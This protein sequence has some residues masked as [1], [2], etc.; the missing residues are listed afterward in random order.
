MKEE[1]VLN[2]KYLHYLLPARVGLGPN[3]GSTLFFPSLA[4]VVVQT[5]LL[6]WLHKTPVKF[7]KGR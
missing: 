4:I 1:V 6:W 7:V 2:G 3:F 5:V